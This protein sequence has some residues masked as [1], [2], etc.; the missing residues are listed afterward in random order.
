MINNLKIFLGKD[1]FYVLFFIILIST[2][3]AFIEIIVLNSLALFVTL[4]V[5]SSLFLKNLP[6]ENL[7]IYFS[8]LSKQDLIYQ[9][10]FFILAIVLFKSIIITLINY[11]PKELVIW[12]KS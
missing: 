5:D 4:L 8:N 9:I 3:S 2:L 7:K 1:K 11:F 12:K 10:S 6:F